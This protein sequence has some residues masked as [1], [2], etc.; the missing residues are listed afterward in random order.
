MK[1]QRTVPLILLLVEVNEIIS[2]HL[3]KTN[4]C[5][6]VE[7][8]NRKSLDCSHQNLSYIPNIKSD[9]QTLVFSYNNL[10]N[11]T[12]NTFGNFSN[13]G[14]LVELELDHNNIQNI[15]ANSLDAF[16]N[17][18]FLYLSYNPIHYNDL[19]HLLGALSNFRYLSH[20]SISGIRSITI[21]NDLF[22][23]M[24]ENRIE[25]LDVAF[26]DM[27]TVSID[28]FRNFNRLETLFLNSNHIHKIILSYNDHLHNLYLDHNNFKII[29]DFYA[30]GDESN[31]HI[32]NLELLAI[33]KNEIQKIEA[34]DLKCLFQLK[35][36][37]LGENPIEI[38]QNNILLNLPNLETLELVFAPSGSIKV[39]PLAFRSTSLNTLKLELNSPAKD[40]FES[41]NDTFKYLPNLRNLKLGFISM[42]LLSKQQLSRLFSPLVNIRFFQCFAC[43]ISQDPE[44]ILKHMKNVESVYLQSNRIPTLSDKTVEENTHLKYL[45]LKNNAIGH[46]SESALPI[47]LLNKLHLIDLS[48]NPFVCD[49]D[50]EWFINWMKTNK[51]KTVISGY[52]HNYTCSLPHEKSKLRLLDIT[53]TYKECHPWSPWIWVAVIG[54]PCVIVI[55]IVVVIVYRNRWNIKHYIYLVRKRRNYQVIKGHNLVYDA[56]VGY[57]TTDSAWVRRRLLPILEDEEG[58]KLCIHERDFVPG[59]FINDNIVTNM[60]RSA[61]IILVITNAFARSGWCTF[62]LKVAH[63]KL[64]EDETELVFILLEKIDGRNMNHSLKVLFDTTTYIEWTED[65]VGQ[66]LF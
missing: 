66:E 42:F 18:R 65:I 8:H 7:L 62:E 12:S 37:E 46:I 39:E 49:C 33:R 15:S 64:I 40:V 57:D 47:L 19:K 56:F 55:A 52:P 53:F 36:L 60:D 27:E 30:E 54:S 32:P 28:T 23:L 16:S 41:L 1:L 63:S 9:I 31:C 3:E 45:N 2:A 38:L 10:T 43:E 6:E 61:K 34:K 4:T 13:P 11:V 24:K 5:K 59:V 58:L 35:T 44:V 29:P 26:Y 50:L 22:S 51:N 25:T 48:Q 21:Q 20:L 14:N 17:L